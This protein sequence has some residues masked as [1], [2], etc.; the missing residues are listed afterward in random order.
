MG[1]QLGRLKTWYIKSNYNNM[2]FSN[3]GS[4]IKTFFKIE[5]IFIL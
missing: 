2:V 5:L 1:A 3:M 4:K